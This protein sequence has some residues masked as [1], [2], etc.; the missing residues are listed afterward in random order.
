MNVG[1]RRHAAR[2][3]VE[4]TFRYDGP[5][6]SVR[7]AIGSRAAL[8]GDRGILDAAEESPSQSS[9]L[10][11]ALPSPRLPRRA[12]SGRAGGLLSVFIHAGLLTA[13]ITTGAWW[14]IAP[15]PTAPDVN[16]APSPVADMVF[17]VVAA[18]G[19]GGGGGG[20]RQSRPPSRAQGIGR[21]RLTIPAAKATI[22]PLPTEAIA[23]GQQ[24]VVLDAVP[25]A[26]GT[27]MLAGLPEAPLSVPISQ[28]PGSGGGVGDGT[29][30]G[31]GSG[32]GPGMGAGTGG[33]FGGGAYRP[34]A[35]V[36]L[37]T[38]VS[39][40][41]PTYTSEAM[42]LRLQG[43]VV[44][45]VVVGRDG[46]PGAIRVIRSLDRGLDE[47]A[48]EAAGKWRFA[49]GRIGDTPVEVLVTILMDFSLR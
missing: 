30:T 8:P 17:V 38:V 18:P 23:A 43:S 22:T 36:V 7:R 25:M 31:I 41:K 12:W 48:I 49:P 5:H 3:P 13:V 34:G 39:M 6:T 35:G 32:S 20:N 27:A 1:I 28:G 9:R 21:D 24:Q 26:S 15:P 33:G 40:V 10:G 2:S 4:G 14:G 37:P 42:R 47:E 45:E 19:G 16:R 44:L 11:L 46:I 29:G